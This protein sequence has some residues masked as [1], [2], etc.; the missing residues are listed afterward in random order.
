VFALSVTQL[1]SI[2]QIF[3]AQQFRYDARQVAF[4]LVGMAALMAGIQGG[5]IRS[6]AA[7]FPERRLVQVGSLLMAASFA[8]I[9]LA[10]SL[11]PLLA[12][13]ALSA[14]GRSVIQPSLLSLTAGAAAPVHRGAALGAFQASA[15]LARIFG[16]YAAGWLY[17]RRLGAPFLLAAGLAACLSLLARTLP[18]R[19]AT[20][21]DVTPAPTAGA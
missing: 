10:D 20:A 15:S 2:F 17:D 18:G 19:V 16:P 11:L 12:V 13:L 9:P 8:L 14:G 3:M 5:G 1:E 6:L 21:A 4:I 7:R